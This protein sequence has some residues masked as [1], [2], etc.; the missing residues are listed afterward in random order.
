MNWKILASPWGWISPVLL[1]LLLALDGLLAWAITYRPIN[2]LSFVMGFIILLNLGGIIYLLYWMWRYFGM[3]YTMD[4]NAVTIS[5]GGIRQVIP[6]DRI[7]DIILGKDVRVAGRLPP[8]WRLPGLYVESVELVDYGMCLTCSRRTL[9]DQ[10]I[11]LTP[12]LGYAISPERPGA[13]TT[14]LLLRRRL[15]PLQ[16]VSQETLINDWLVIPFWTDAVAQALWL[17]GLMLSLALLGFL[18]WRFASLPPIVSMHVDMLGRP[19]R[20]GEKVGLFYLAF[21][22]LGMVFLNG[23]AGL[24]VHKYDRVLTLI[25]YSGAAL[26]QAWLWIAILTLTR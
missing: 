8:R 12:T 3:R 4:R 17:A 14:D 23:I 10:L 19:D 22:G 24:G 9:R 5:C 11:L 6:V 18:T 2:L 15:G 25:L 13:F 21:V 1:V 26:M 7:V 16:I 20:L